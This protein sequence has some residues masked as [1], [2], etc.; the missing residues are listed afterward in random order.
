M[1]G[2]FYAS[3]SMLEIL[4]ED[5]IILPY[6]TGGIMTKKCCKCKETKD[7]SDFYKKKANISDGLSGICKKCDNKMKNN[8][9]KRNLKKVRAYEKART[10]DKDGKKRKMDNER[11]RKNRL[12]M[13]DSYMRELITK[14]SSLDPKDLSDEF[15]EAYKI[16]LKL[17]R[18]L[19]LT[20]KLKPPPT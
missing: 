10:W 5:T 1:I 13:S 14:K 18:E 2:K 6:K 19:E 3:T 15:I 7:L 20:P 16:N 9:R 4:G 17:K 11:S 8:W 12:E